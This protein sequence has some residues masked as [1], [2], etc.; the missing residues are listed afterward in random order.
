MGIVYLLHF[1]KKYK[2]AQHYIGYTDNL[3]KRLKRHQAK[4]GSKFVAAMLNN[5]IN[6]LLA[7]TWEGVDY[8]FERKLKNRH[9]S[10]MFC[11]I[12]KNEKELKNIAKKFNISPMNLSIKLYGD[13]KNDK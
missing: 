7:R 3:E 4:Q 5:G 1:E 2:H 12:C 13:N 8:S 11:P 9:K 6:F 10:S